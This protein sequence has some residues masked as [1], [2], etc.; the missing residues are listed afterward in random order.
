[1]TVTDK[2]VKLT[3]KEQW[4]LEQAGE[5]VIQAVMHAVDKHG[6]EGTPLNPD[7]DPYRA[8][9]IC[10]EEVGEAAKALVEAED[11]YDNEALQPLLEELDQ[12]AACYLMWRA[13]HFLSE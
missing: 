9:A 8:N 3:M 12:A 6:A 7:M 11:L 13:S 2:R 4:A 5:A 10:M 1:M